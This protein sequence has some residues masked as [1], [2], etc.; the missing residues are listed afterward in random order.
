VNVSI[1]QFVQTNFADVIRKALEDAGL[2]PEGLELEVTESLLA[3]D[4]EG[5]VRTLNALKEIGVQLSIDDFGTGYSSM[6]HLKNFPVDRIKIDRSFVTGISLDPD[7]V[8]ITMAVLSMAKSMRLSVVAE[9]VETQEQMNFFQEKLCEQVQGYFLS[10]PVPAE[11]LTAFVKEYM[12][13]KKV[14][15][16]LNK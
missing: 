6:S 2:E 13:S 8:A 1:A 9:G 10:R 3:K 11:D 14:P 15:S 16:R 5:S 12:G 7:D 4:V